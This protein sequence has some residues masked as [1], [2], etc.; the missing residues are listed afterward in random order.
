MDN[1]TDNIQPITVGGNS[2][3]FAGQKAAAM[4]GKKL[5]Q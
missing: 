4:L 2:D 5:Q 1:N 3:G